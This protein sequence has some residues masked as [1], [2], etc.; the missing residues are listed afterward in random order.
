MH[1]PHAGHEGDPEPDEAQEDGGR[2]VLDFLDIRPRELRQ[3]GSGEGGEGLD[4]LPLGFGID[5]VEEEGRLSRTG[6]A[7]HGHESVLGDRAGNGLQV[8][9]AGFDDF[10]R[11]VRHE[12]LLAPAEGPAAKSHDIRLEIVGGNV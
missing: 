9:D 11:L 1:G 10:N 5:R 7:R 12:R 3:T 4:K 6:D 8:V 2:Q